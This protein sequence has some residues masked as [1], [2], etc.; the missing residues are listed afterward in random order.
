MVTCLCRKGKERNGKERKEQ[1]CSVSALIKS[2]YQPFWKKNKNVGIT[3]GEWRKV[4]PNNSKVVSLASIFSHPFNLQSSIFNLQLLTTLRKC[5]FWVET[6]NPIIL[7]LLYFPCLPSTAIMDVVS[8]VSGYISK[9]VSTGDTTL[10][11][12]SAKMKI[13]LLDSETV[14][15]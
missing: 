2:I 12:S 3:D 15:V 14:R 1:F 6:P 13:L 5:S 10:A 8:A 9:M 4:L 11:S 7:K